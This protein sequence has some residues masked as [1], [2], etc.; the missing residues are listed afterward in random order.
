MRR[1]VSKL[2]GWQD[3]ASGLAERLAHGGLTGQ[4]VDRGN[5]DNAVGNAVGKAVDEMVVRWGGWRGE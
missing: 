5:V 3:G 4:W 1:A 2:V